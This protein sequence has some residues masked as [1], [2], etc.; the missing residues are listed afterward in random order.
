MGDNKQ[1]TIQVKGTAYRF[2]PIPL[3]DIEKVNLVLHMNA[4]PMKSFKML[5]RVISESAGP[6]QWDALTDLL[7]ES[8]VTLDEITSQIFSKICKRQMKD[9]KDAKAETAADVE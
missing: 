6:D 1:Y 4:S 5:T 3:G 9:M 2:Q 7:I 8:Q